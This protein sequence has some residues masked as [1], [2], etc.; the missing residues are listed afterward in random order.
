MTTWRHA[1]TSTHPLARARRHGSERTKA[2]DLNGGGHWPDENVIVDTG[3]AGCRFRGNDQGL[4][5]SLA[6]DR[7]PKLDNSVLDGNAEF[8]RRQPSQRTQFGVE[9]AADLLIRDGLYRGHD[10]AAFGERA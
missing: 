1:R 10:I 9:T 4:V 3:D 6:V 5:F 7:C 8:S 2:D